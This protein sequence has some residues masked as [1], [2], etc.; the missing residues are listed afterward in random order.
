MAGTRSTG[1]TGRQ[2]EGTT[3]DELQGGRHRDPAKASATAER[4]VAAA[5]RVLARGGPSA[6]TV[7]SVAEEAG[8]YPD[9]VRYHFGG[10]AGLVAAVVHSLVNDQ[11]FRAIARQ[12]GAAPR[13]E[14]IHQLTVA[15]GE[16]LLDRDS[17]RDFFALLAAVLPDPEL[18]E[19]IAELYAGYRTLYEGVLRSGGDLS[20]D[21]AAVLATLMN[22]VVDGLAVQKLLDPDAVQVDRVLSYWE[23]LVRRAIE[24]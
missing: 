6:L 3:G 23:E 7:Q 13:D 16:L 4:L 10:K 17:Y 18:R 1:Q 2:M 15:D 19:R 8:T 21:E 12:S 5:R 22:A 11:N 24:G 9:S 14:V 20:D